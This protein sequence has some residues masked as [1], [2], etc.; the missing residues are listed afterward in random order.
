MDIQG[1]AAVVTEALLVT[2]QD[3][4]R[5]GMPMQRQHVQQVVADVLAKHWPQE[6]VLSDVKAD[7]SQFGDKKHIPPTPAQV[8]A[9]SASIGYPLDGAAW[10]DSYQQKGWLVGKVKMKDWQS[11]VRNWKRSGYGQ[12]SIAK[13]PKPETDKRDYG[14]I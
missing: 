2:K 10:C 13:G 3:M 4:S 8:E 6:A 14:Q 9:Y 1:I 11:A 12:G 7:S 5:R